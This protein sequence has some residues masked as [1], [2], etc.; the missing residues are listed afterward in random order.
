MYAEL[1]IQPTAA[2]VAD[3]YHGLL[4]GFVLDRLD[5]TLEEDIR[6]MGLTPLVTNTL[7]KT[8]EDRCHLAQ[9]VLNLIQRL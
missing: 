8:R 3:H 7:M 6:K 9:D 2:A 4:K 5:L 1:G